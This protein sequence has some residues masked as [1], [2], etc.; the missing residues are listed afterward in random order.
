MSKADEFWKYAEE[1][2]RRVTESKSDKEKEALI[3]LALTWMQAAIRSENTVMGP[4]EQEAGYGPPQSAASS[5]ITWAW[6]ESFWPS[7]RVR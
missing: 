4:P 3:D 7:R 6:P 2:M 1:A 5:P